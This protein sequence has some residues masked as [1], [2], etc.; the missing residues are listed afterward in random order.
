MR[1]IGG[2]I[3]ALIALFC[4][5]CSL[6]F[7]YDDLTGK[8]Y[9]FAIIWGPGLL[10]AGL[11]GWGAVKLRANPAPSAKTPSDDQTPP[12]SDH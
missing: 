9:G 6:L 4:G 12:N 8:G 2:A 5:G 3:L 1:P 11:S 7:G 10:I